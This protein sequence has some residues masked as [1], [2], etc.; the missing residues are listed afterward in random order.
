V[1]EITQGAA[2]L[3]TELRRG[4]DV[5][6]DYGLRVFP[7]TAEPGEVTIGL[8]FTDEPVAG[9]QVTEA[10]GMKVFVAQELAAPLEDAAIDVAQQDGEEQLVF[11]PKHQTPTPS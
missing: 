9:D 7:E 3:L 6:D 5:P 4:Q 2:A 11:R 10:D 1:L 8:G